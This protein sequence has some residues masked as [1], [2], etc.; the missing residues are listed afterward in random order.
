MNLPKLTTP[1]GLFDYLIGL[2]VALAAL[3]GLYL[4]AVAMD[5]IPPLF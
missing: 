5:I 2:L 3:A 4:A 1:T